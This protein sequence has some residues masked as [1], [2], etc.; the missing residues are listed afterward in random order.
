MEHC[1]EKPKKAAMKEKKLKKMLLEVFVER[2]EE[3][4]VWYEISTKEEQGT[5]SQ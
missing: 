1:D 3:K 5:G 2:E 4:R